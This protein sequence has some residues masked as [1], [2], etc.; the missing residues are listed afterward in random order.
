LSH[1]DT[2]RGPASSW[3]LMAVA[4]GLCAASS[5]KLGFEAWLVRGFVRS[6]LS[7]L[8]RTALLLG[9]PLERPAGLR[10]FLGVVGG[11]VLPALAIVAAAT[12]SP[13][14]TAAFAVVALAASIAGE[15]AERY[16]FFTAVVKPNMPGG[17]LP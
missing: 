8:R 9:G 11:V 13:V 4:L 6:E 12:A 14:A 7:P 1:A 17:L 15:T 5:A 2:L 3:P 10:R 16:L